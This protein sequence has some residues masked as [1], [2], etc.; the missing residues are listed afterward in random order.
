MMAGLR[1]HLHCSSRLV[2]PHVG[3]HSGDVHSG[4]LS[5]AKALVTTE[6]KNNER[7]KPRVTPFMRKSTRRG[8]SRR[9]EWFNVADTVGNAS[10]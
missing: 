2:V 7:I 4:R 10:E 5:D 3:L 8:H 6:A 1:A 9:N